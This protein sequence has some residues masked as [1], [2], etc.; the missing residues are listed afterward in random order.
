MHREFELFVLAV[1]QAATAAAAAPS[2]STRP[3][4]VAVQHGS[5]AVPGVRTMQPQ[6]SYFSISTGGDAEHVTRSM[7]TLLPRYTQFSDFVVVHFRTTSHEYFLAECAQSAGG[8]CVEARRAIEGPGHEFQIFQDPKGS[9]G[10]IDE[11]F[12]LRI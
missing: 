11:A 7:A 6:I 1:L 3:D 12:G 5:I 9:Y 10:F 2:T 8:G 4:R